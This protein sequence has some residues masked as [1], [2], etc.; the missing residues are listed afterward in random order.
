MA[1]GV[2]MVIAIESILNIIAERLKFSSV[3]IIV[4]T[5]SFSLYECLVKLG[6]IKEKRLMI[7]IMALKQAY[8]QKDVFEIRW[9]N[10]QDNLADVI[11]KAIS[12]RALSTFIDINRLCLRVQGW[13]Q[14]GTQGDNGVTEG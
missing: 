12:N 13:V 1:N 7:D 6:T 3:S 4:Y 2:N 9:I 11:T 14:R 5:N 8:E 10:G